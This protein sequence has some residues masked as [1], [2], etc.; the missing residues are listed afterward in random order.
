MMYPCAVSIPVCKLYE[1]WNF[2]ASLYT[3]YFISITLISIL[4]LRFERDLK[5]ILV[6]GG[7]RTLMK[8]ALEAYFSSEKCGFGV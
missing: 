4:R 5:G 8:R 1:N 2:R 7:M 3:S 6:F